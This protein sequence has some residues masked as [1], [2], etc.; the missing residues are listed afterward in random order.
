MTVYGIESVTFVF[1]IIIS[2]ICPFTFGLQNLLLGFI[3]SNGTFSKQTV[4][5]VLR[6][7]GTQLVVIYDLTVFD[8][9]FCKNVKIIWRL[10]KLAVGYFFYVLPIGMIGYLFLFV[11]SNSFVCRE[12]R[13]P[14]LL[15]NNYPPAVNMTE[16]YGMRIDYY[17]EC[18]EY[19]SELSEY[20]DC[21]RPRIG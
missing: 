11:K 4:G 12:M 15:D 19:V 3:L 13:A 16:L 9:K 10:G 18:D 7:T 14:F 5:H 2:L 17:Y 8:R 21:Q 1:G 6:T 20:D